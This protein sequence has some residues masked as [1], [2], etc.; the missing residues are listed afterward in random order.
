MKSFCLGHS[1]SIRRNLLGPL[2][3]IAFLLAGQT[4]AQEVVQKSIKVDG[5]SVS[6]SVLQSTGS[7][8]KGILLLFPGKGE[9]PKSVFKKTTLPGI[10]AAQGYTTIV[11]NL[12]YA[13]FADDLARKQLSEILKTESEGL[14]SP[15]LIIGGFSA[16]GAVALSYA[17]YIVSQGATNLKS[18][19]AIDPPLDLQRLYASSRLMRRYN[20]PS[21]QSEAQG[22]ID[23]LDKALGGSPDDQYA[24]YVANSPYMASEA[25]GGNA[26]WLRQVPIRLYAEPDVDFVKERHCAEMERPDL[27]VGDLEKLVK[28]LKKSGNS[29]CELVLTKGRGYHS[30]DIADADE[31]A[32]WIGK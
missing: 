1:Y 4:R 27:N 28:D 16:G 8:S 25:D 26:R 23:Y 12:K 5:K 18:L 10:L 19:F 31:L 13:L 11:P 15:A 30:W 6:Y 7:A 29:A 32:A 14:S 20:C 22:N 2:V 3:V 17:E 9:N 24:N 21:V